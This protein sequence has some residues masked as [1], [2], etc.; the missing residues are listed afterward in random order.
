MKRKLTSLLIAA[1][2]SFGCLA[3]NQEFAAASAANVTWGDVDGDSYVLVE[4]AMLLLRRYTD[5]LTGN[6]VDYSGLWN[7]GDVNG[8]GNVSVDDAQLVLNKYVEE[9]VG[10]SYYFP[11]ESP[12]AYGKLYTTEAWNVYVKANNAHENYL[13]IVREKSE[14]EIIQYVGDCWYKIECSDFTK[15]VFI[16]IPLTTWKKK[17]FYVG[18]K[19]DEIVPAETTTT[20]NTTA[21]TTTQTTS[22]EAI[23][24][25]TTE[26]TSQEA[27]IET[28]TTMSTT[29]TMMTTTTTHD[30]TTET[31][32]TQ[33]TETQTTTELYVFEVGDKIEFQAVA[34]VLFSNDSKEEQVRWL[35][36]GEKFL[37]VDRKINDDEDFARYTIVIEEDDEED[38]EKQYV[39]HI[40]DV[41]YFK[42]IS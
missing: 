35:K 26:T 10:N 34:W 40:G 41:K 24:Q 5:T 42:K 18:E 8:D 15:N 19:A 29:T 25:T 23:V 9:M 3:T 1:M 39:I 6:K 7:L 16:N 37:I 20:L 33:T 28:T 21:E 2:V 30:T 4:D 11:V 13:G 12:I 17:F 32:A 14:F 22:Q 27:S 31:T 36:T 38:N